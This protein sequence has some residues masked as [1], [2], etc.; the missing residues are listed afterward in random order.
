MTDTKSFLDGLL[1][2][3][4][5]EREAKV[6][7]ALFNKRSAS[8]S[9]LQK[10]SGVR[11]N[12]INEVVNN[13]VRQGFCL[14]RKVGNR[15]YFD[16]IDPNS[17]MMNPL[18]KLESR[19]DSGKKLTKMLGK[20]YSESEAGKEPLEY[21]EILRG[22]DNI[23]NHYCQ[24][25]R[26][27]SKELLVFTR[28]PYAC[29]TNEKVLEQIKEYIDLVK[30]EAEIRMI[31]EMHT[32]PSADLGWVIKKLSKNGVNLRTSTTLPLKMMVF[33]RQEVLVAQE[34]LLASSGELVMASIRQNTIADAFRAL[35][36]FFWNQAT[37]FK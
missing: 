25:V 23:H 11:Q 4:L 24:L 1:D 7:L 15:R 27:A 32:E 6:Y 8:L 28:P 12:K 22:N 33:D 5:S 29:N 37:E 31:Y 16:V 14:E 19:L 20:L 10:L 30:R 9:D 26:R 21:I 35:F 36:E 2:F 13:L 18:K 34:E 17:S 3:G